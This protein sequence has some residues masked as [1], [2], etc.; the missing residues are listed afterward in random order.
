MRMARLTTRF[1]VL[2]LAVFLVVA[3]VLS[4]L[5][6]RWIDA[7]LIQRTEAKVEQNIRGAWR[8]LDERRERLSLAVRLAAACR[9]ATDPAEIERWRAASDADL[10]A[11]AG[12]APPGATG[13]GVLA[14]LLAEAIP[15]GAGPEVSGFA[16]VPADRLSRAAPE[17]AARAGVAGGGAPALF[18]FAAATVDPAPGGAPRRIVGALLLNGADRLV[19]AMQSDLFPDA[20]YR[21]QRVGTAT[22]FSGPV[23]VATTVLQRDGRGAA[24]TRVSDEVAARVLEQGRPWTGRANV[25]GTWYLAR[26]DP[27]RD[28]GGRVVGMLYIGELERIYADLKRRALWTGVGALLAIM[29]P[30]LV[31]GAGLAMRML[32]KVRTLDAATQAFARGDF[33]A[34]APVAGRDELDHL[35]RSFNAMAA[36]IEADR[37]RILEQ[38]RQIEEANRN[39]IDLLG[40][41]AHELRNGVASALLNVQTVDEGACGD[42]GPD[43]REALR[44]VADA[45]RRINGETINYL[46]LAR[47]EEGHR[48]IER[49]PVRVRGDVVDPV[50]ESLRPVLRRS[51]QQV[52]NDIADDLVAAGDRDLLRVVFQN[53]VHNAA[54]F[55]R[56]GGRI[57]LGARPEPGRIVFHVWN[58]GEGIPPGRMAELFKKFRHFDA[59]GPA[60]QSG[61]GV[62]LFIVRRIVQA[63]G[64]DI[65]AA[66]EPGAW[67]DF[68]FHLL[69]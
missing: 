55:G 67:A 69:T 3:A 25:V 26:Y 5:L 49:R 47:I 66:S 28:P 59:G 1:N 9:G 35:A 16:S 51:G 41:V 20:F 46:Q 68:E 19:G 52:E 65:R 45:L 2:L 15:A 6:D 33:A 54:K 24:G 63:H 39:Y 22:V 50:L 27:I 57:V 29:I 23:R 38:Q 4:A 32:R 37:A 48:L 8:V 60:G 58:D 14:A 31:V 61:T 36:V 34:R 11:V 13:A 42:V 10:L 53:L 56:P 62:G 64:G 17:L 40:F 7:W 43:V 21:G 12:D 44:T 30:A 18:L